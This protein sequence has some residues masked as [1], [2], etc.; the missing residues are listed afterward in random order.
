MRY[1][2]QES[3]R[4]HPDSS[5]MGMAQGLG[6]FSIALGL[7]EVLAPGK[8]ARG[9]GM[10]G[11]EKTIFG[12]GLREIATGIGILASKDPTPWIWGRVGGDA[13]DLATLAPGLHPDNPKRENVGLAVAAVLGATAADVYCAQRLSRDS[14]E[15]LPPVHDY[16]DRSGLPRPAGAMRGAATDVEVPR[17]FRTPEA[18]RPFP[19]Q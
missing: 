10:E 2:T 15:P 13:L 1:M 4:G 18:L 5:G 11:Q 14:A 6:L 8:L 17:E 16:S 19:V 3:Y 9:L 7:M 12:Y